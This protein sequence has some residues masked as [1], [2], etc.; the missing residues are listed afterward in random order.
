MRVLPSVNNV[1][2]LLCIYSL[3]ALAVLLDCIN[4]IINILPLFAG[5]CVGTR[6]QLPSHAIT[7]RV[8]PMMDAMMTVKFSNIFSVLLTVQVKAYVRIITQ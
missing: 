4:Y 2:T 1:L 7:K 3:N 5:S 8:Y 6:T